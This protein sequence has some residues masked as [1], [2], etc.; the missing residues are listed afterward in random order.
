MVESVVVGDSAVKL[1]C[2]LRPV[3][4]E[5]HVMVAT[6]VREAGPAAALLARLP[7]DAVE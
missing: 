3:G 5:I 2:A 4:R 7:P 6:A 1:A